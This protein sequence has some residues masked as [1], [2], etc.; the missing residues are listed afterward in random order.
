MRIQMAG[1]D[2]RPTNLSGHN[3]MAPAK[4]SVNDRAMR[5]VPVALVLAELEEAHHQGRSLTAPAS[6]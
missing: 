6:R 4:G 5:L 2:A 3:V 1:R